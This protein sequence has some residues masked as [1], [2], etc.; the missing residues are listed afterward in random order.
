M[1]TPTLTTVQLAI[2][3]A[4][5]SV[6]GVPVDS[7]AVVLAIK[8]GPLGVEMTRDE[9]DA[10]LFW[11]AEQELTWHDCATAETLAVV[12]WTRS[13]KGDALLATTQPHQE[14]FDVS[15]AIGFAVALRGADKAARLIIAACEEI[16]A[17]RRV[18]GAETPAA[19]EVE[20]ALIRERLSGNVR[21]GLMADLDAAVEARV[22][23][24]SA[25]DGVSANGRDRAEA[26]ARFDEADH[27]VAEA[28]RALMAHDGALA[29]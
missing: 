20:A 10:R 27:A 3:R 26:I 29:G 9:V 11:L 16:A 2:L 21:R 28:H 23:A 12:R 7:L 1:T 17:W 13:L 14:P 8:S 5:P 18:T 15:A 19:L 4:L 24:A 25:M 22:V 6:D